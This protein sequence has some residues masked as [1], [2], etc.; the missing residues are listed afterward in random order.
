MKTFLEAKRLDLHQT[1]LIFHIARQNGGQIG[2]AVLREGSL[3]WYT[4][5]AQKGHRVRWEK[6]GALIQ[7]AVPKRKRRKARGK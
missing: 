5:N 1:P 6:L 4:G 2:R 3:T 7:R